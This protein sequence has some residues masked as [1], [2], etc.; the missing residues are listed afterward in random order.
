MDR[1]TARHLPTATDACTGCFASN[2]ISV[3]GRAPLL[4]RPQSRAEPPSRSEWYAAA[5]SDG[6]PNPWA[7]GAPDATPRGRQWTRHTSDCH[8][9]CTGGALAR[10]APWLTTHRVVVQPAI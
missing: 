9:E 1:G 2:T 5:R 10:R 8:R 6:S 3:A 4:A 7:P